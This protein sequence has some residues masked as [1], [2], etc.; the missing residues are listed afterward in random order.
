MVLAQCLDK[1][2]L[3]A[4]LVSYLKKAQLLVKDSP[5]HLERVKQEEFFFNES[6]VRSY[7]VYEAI[8]HSQTKVN[9]RTNAIRIDGKLDEEDWKKLKSSS[10]SSS[11]PA[12]R[13]LQSLQLGQEWFLTI[14]IS[15]LPL[16]V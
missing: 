12:I 5:I 11:I 7:R 10:S 16:N 15:T 2:G 13:R 8:R 3:E 14:I 9:M 6:W 4:K 1:P